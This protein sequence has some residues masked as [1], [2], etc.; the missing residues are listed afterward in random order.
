MAAERA[1]RLRQHRLLGIEPGVRRLAGAF[2]PAHRG[3]AEGDEA[4][5]V[6]ELRRAVIGARSVERGGEFF[7]PAGE[8]RSA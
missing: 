4:L 2:Q 5:I 6:G 7:Q 3:G 8:A 1:L